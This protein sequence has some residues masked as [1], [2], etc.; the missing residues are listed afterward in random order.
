MPY[1]KLVLPRNFLRDINF[2]VLKK[3]VKTIKIF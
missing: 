3:Y 2:A 1:E